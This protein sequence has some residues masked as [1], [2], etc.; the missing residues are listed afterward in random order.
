MT[1]LPTYSN[2]THTQEQQFDKR[3]RRINP[4]DFTYSSEETAV[5]SGTGADWRR[6]WS[7]TGGV[8]VAAA[9]D[10]K[11]AA[12]VNKTGKSLFCPN[13]DNRNQ[14]TEL[15]FVVLPG[16]PLLLSRR[17]GDSIGLR[18][19]GDRFSK[20]NIAAWPMSMFEIRANSTPRNSIASVDSLNNFCSAILA[21]FLTPVDG[22]YEV[23]W[24]F[25]TVKIQQVGRTRFADSLTDLPKTKIEIDKR[26]FF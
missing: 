6:L 4:R 16:N 8:G 17:F 14:G 21:M 7:S 2:T 23:V 19:V 25:P 13:D 18:S 22:R 24:L 20:W 10:A 3:E 26:S 12:L 11:M 9:V 15:P 5:W 1:Y